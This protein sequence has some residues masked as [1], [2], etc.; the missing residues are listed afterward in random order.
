M[1]IKLTQCLLSICLMLAIALP[2]QNSDNQKFVE[3]TGR[4]EVAYFPD[5]VQY[6]IVISDYDNLDANDE[7][8]SPDKAKEYLEMRKIKMQERYKQIWQV[9]KTE[10]I[11]ENALVLE[12]KYDIQNLNNQDYLNKSFMVKFTDFQKFKRIILK[13]K[14]L[15]GVNGQIM[16]AQAKN[17]EELRD[18]AMLS[19]IE[20][21]KLKANKLA[22]AVNSTVGNVLQIRE[23]N[24]IA[25][26]LDAGWTAYPSLGDIP[27]NVNSDGLSRNEINEEGKFVLRQAVL[28]KFSLINN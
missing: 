12:E 8:L 9:L 7:P 15:K 11:T 27:Q 10:G 4:G 19:A 21:A 24:D 17:I 14:D 18:K 6:M 22:K 23:T 28:I 5:M 13:I 25:P 1:K 16:D 2:A 3:I 20:D 26:T